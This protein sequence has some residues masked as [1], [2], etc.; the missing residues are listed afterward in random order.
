MNSSKKILLLI[1]LL[2]MGCA[3]TN[4]K[5]IVDGTPAANPPIQKPYHIN[6]PNGS[7][8]GNL[9]LS[10]FSNHVEYIPLETKKESLFRGV[11]YFEMYDLLSKLH[12][13][14]PLVTI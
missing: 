3:N 13:I 2:S 10:D 7:S 14:K 1:L 11:A 6:L 8:E 9:R 5:K 12:S 4:Q